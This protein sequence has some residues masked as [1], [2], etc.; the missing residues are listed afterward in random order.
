MAATGPEAS[1]G[2]VFSLYESA[3]CSFLLIHTASFSCLFWCFMF[4]VTAAGATLKT[5][6]SASSPLSFIAST[7]LYYC[8]LSLL[9]R[10]PGILSYKNL[11]LKW[12]VC[13]LCGVLLKHQL[14]K[15]DIFLRKLAGRAV[16]T[17]DFKSQYPPSFHLRFGILLSANKKQ[18]NSKQ[19]PLVAENRTHDLLAAR[20]KC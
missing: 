5:F 6:R 4:S 7:A 10:T 11:I 14:C 9:F 13:A 18:P 3:L 20:Q 16:K 12:C 15:R 1:P 8:Y 17:N 19:K 2:N